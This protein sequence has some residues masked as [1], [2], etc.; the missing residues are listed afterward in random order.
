MDQAGPGQGTRL[1]RGKAPYRDRVLE[2]LR[3]RRYV[4]L[5]ALMLVVALACV[6]AGT[7]QIMREIQKH[8][9]NSE[10]RHNAHAPAASAD[11]VLPLVGA[12]PGP[13][14][15]AV[16][17]RTVTATGSYDG[18][19]QALVRQRTVNGDTGYL[20]LTPL[21][22]S[23]AT[24]LVVRGFVSGTSSEVVSAP[25]RR[26]DRSRSPGASSRPRRAPIRP[27]HCRAVRSSR[28]TRA[29]RRPGW[30][31]RSS[32]GTWSCWTV[33]LAPRG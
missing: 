19:H 28:S 14:D 21:R 33:S 24:L 23:N 6:G 32:T 25:R 26:R 16:Q 1:R 4:A 7:W 22:T 15:H 3:Q 10:L 11:S 9:A 5:S 2:T 13:A 27:P 30:L 29:S 17:Y 18:A 8:D 31:H 12:G 20:V